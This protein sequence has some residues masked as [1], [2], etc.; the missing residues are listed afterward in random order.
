MVDTEAQL[1]G[2]LVAAQADL[3]S[4]RQVYTD[5]NIRV[6]T[7]RAKVDALK[8]QVENMSGNKGDPGSDA[9]PDHR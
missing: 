4:L 6:R 5:N 9:F 7:V 1:Q 2:N 8:H 3:E